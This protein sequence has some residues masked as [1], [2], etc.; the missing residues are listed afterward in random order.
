MPARQPQPGT[1]WLLEC[2]AVLL[3][4]RDGLDPLRA[5]VVHI[6]A[7]LGCQRVS[8]GLQVRGS[9][10]S[11]VAVSDLP[12]PADA[13]EFVA[14]LLAAMHDVQSS[15]CTLTFPPVGEPARHPALGHV[16]LGRSLGGGALC[17][18]PLADGGRVLGVLTLQRDAAEP[19]SRSEAARIELVCAFLAPLLHLQATAAPGGGRSTGTGLPVWLQAVRR[20]ARVLAVLAAAGVAALPVP[21]SVAALATVRGVQE[22][23]LAAPRDGYVAQVHA[24]PGQSVRVGETLVALD[25]ESARNDLRTAQAALDQAETGFSEA[26]ARGEQG[27]VVVQVARIEEGLARVAAARQAMERGRIAAPADGI[28]VDGD[29]TRSIGAPVQ[30]GQVLMTVAPAQG[31]RIALWVDERD[32]GRVAAGQA[33]TLRLAARPG[34]AVPLE[35][36]RLTPLASV[37]DG[38][39]GFE[40]E[41]RPTGEVSGLRPGYE[42]VARLHDGREPLAWVLLHRAWHAARM[43]WWSLA[44]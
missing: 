6:A 31:H 34:D 35:V 2:V 38:R 10:L 3:Q 18:A 26:M 36:V 37:R 19:F 15:G 14:D 43:R 13:P 29:L 39:N 33:G 11:L 8:L 27:Q 1:A 41:A 4:P 9:P 5:L 28:V 23:Q 7:S 16:Q 12:R 25:E 42:G 22:W 44:G 21:H 40:V 32:I 30:R 20:H 17:S 24:R